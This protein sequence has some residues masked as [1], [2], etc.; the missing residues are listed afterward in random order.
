MAGQRFTPREMLGRLVAFDTPSRE[1]NLPLI[2]FV[3]DY[4]AGW[5]VPSF[6]VD[7]E[8]GKK[9]NPYATVGPEAQDC[10]VLSGHTDVVPVDGQSWTS[11]PFK[12]EERDGRLYGRGTCDMKGFLAVPL[13]MVPEFKAR[14]LKVPIHL[15]LSCDEEVGCRGVRP[16]IAH[17]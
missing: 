10:T 7:Y 3:E 9:T 15:A 13:A 2:D 11:D 14:D 4:L 17:M 1:A 8:P 5:G 12:G 6:R 16:L